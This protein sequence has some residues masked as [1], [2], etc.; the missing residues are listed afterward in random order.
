MRSQR[1]TQGGASSIDT[2][3]K[4]FLQEQLAA[5]DLRDNL[6]PQLLAVISSVLEAIE[7]L[8]EDEHESK[9]G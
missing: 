5:L 1:I 4:Q 6:P 8:E 7:N 9:S 2:Q 3:D